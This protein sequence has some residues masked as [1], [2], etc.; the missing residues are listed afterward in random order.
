MK[1][2]KLKKQEEE[3]RDIIL[4]LGKLSSDAHAS[5]KLLDKVMVQADQLS[6]PRRRFSTWLTQMSVWPSNIGVRLAFAALLVIAIIG[7][8]PQY[9]S[10]FNTHIRD[11][12]SGAIYEDKLQIKLWKKNFACSQKIDKK[13]NKFLIDDG[14]TVT[15]WGCPSGDF[16]VGIEDPIGED[17]Q[18]NI[19]VTYGDDPKT[20]KLFDL[21]VPKA[22]AIDSPQ[23]DML[24]AN[25]VVKVLCQKWLSN[26]YIKRRVQLS[27]KRCFDEVINPGTGKVVKRQEASCNDD[28][29][30]F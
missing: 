5:P 17:P 24:A 25:P 4:S 13:S 22:H 19:W 8:V 16:L 14:R 26:G 11:V 28:C 12:S 15:V 10:W 3:A 7:A 9:I 18:R 27:D 20:T 30:N 23:M 2:N 6:S 29:R 1:H 21:I